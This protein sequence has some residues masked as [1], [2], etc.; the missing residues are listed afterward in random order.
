[1]DTDELAKLRRLNSRDKR[2]MEQVAESPEEKEQGLR[3][4]LQPH[5]LKDL[6]DA[7]AGH[8]Q[9]SGG[10]KQVFAR[11]MLL[12]E[13]ADLQKLQAQRLRKPRGAS[14]MWSRGA[15]GSY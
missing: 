12:K 7:I 8:G 15:T 4:E 6:D 9:Y 10:N 11:P 3:A 13:Q 5:N 1:M 14:G 2:L